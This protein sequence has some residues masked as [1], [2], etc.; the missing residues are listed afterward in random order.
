MSK[1]TPP[2]WAESSK[3]ESLKTRAK[4]LVATTKEKAGPALSRVVDGIG[5]PAQKKMAS[6]NDLMAGS[7]NSL[8]AGL[9]GKS[10]TGEK[11]LELRSTMDELNP[12]SLHNAWW[13]SWMPKGIKRKA[14]SRFIQRY[15]PMQ[16]HVNEIF[17]GLR[18]GKDELL[19]TSIELEHQYDEITE[20]KREIEAEIYIGELFIEQ[21]EQQEATAGDDPQEQQK[22]ATVKNQ[23]MRRIRDLR[24]MEQAA[25]Q[26]FISID[27]TIATNS[28]LSEQI[29]S[30][31]TV[32]PMVM[33]NA[34][35]IQAALAKQK[36]VEKA[37]KGF[38]DGLGD[39][40]AQNAA[41]VN[42]A[43]QNVGDLYNNP[44]I[45]LEKLE[46]GF[47][48][49]MSAVNT[50]N[51][52]MA[53]STTKAREVSD[54][55]SQMTKELEPVAAGSRQARDEANATKQAIKNDPDAFTLKDN[56]DS[57][58]TADAQENAK[59]ENQGDNKNA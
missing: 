44:V 6:A 17:N 57:D 39:M 59:L 1:I 8:L 46:E 25:V 28:L 53:N 51:E 26:F 4:E 14:I 35:R 24:T 52:T 18:A 43:A 15:Q 48:Q 5:A 41:A 34:L 37:V 27:Q 22:L 33:Q 49:L 54:R 32:G 36:A 50:A 11:L 21:V 29:D 58:T 31:L 42:Q 30:A 12:H 45:G 23:A 9:E 38:Q 20:A 47:D 19:E 13:F 40:M 7:V 10:P 3:V 55:L 16:T 2:K 56:K